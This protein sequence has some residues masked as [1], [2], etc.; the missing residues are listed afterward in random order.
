MLKKISAKLP[1][2]VKKEYKVFKCWKEAVCVDHAGVA[3]YSQ[4]QNIPNIK[5]SD[6]SQIKHGKN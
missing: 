1:D 6:F 5:R 3:G 2:L 4:N